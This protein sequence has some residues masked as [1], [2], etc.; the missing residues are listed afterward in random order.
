MLKRLV[1]LIMV[2]GLFGLLPTVAMGIEVRPVPPA[3]PGIYENPDGTWSQW[4]TKPGNPFGPGGE[5]LRIKNY[6]SAEHDI[7]D[8]L[9][10]GLDVQSGT[11]GQTAIDVPGTEAAEVKEVEK[12]MGRLR[13][14][15]KY[16]DPGE[17]AVGDEIIGEAESGGFLPSLG[18][19]AGAASGVVAVAATL[20][21]GIHIGDGIDELLGWPTLLGGGGGLRKEGGFAEIYEWKKKIELNST[22]ACSAIAPAVAA[23]TPPEEVCEAISEEAH[24][25]EEHPV[26]G[27]AFAHEEGIYGPS[28][29]GFLNPPCPTGFALCEREEEEEEH[30]TTFLYLTISQLRHEA[31]PA[32]GLKPGQQHG[33][34]E[35]ESKDVEKRSEQPIGSTPS[36]EGPAVV[37]PFITHE[38]E[39]SLLPGIGEAGEKAAP[40][41]TLATIPE[42][43]PQEKYSEYAPEVEAAGFTNIHEN[44][45]PESEIDGDT[46]PEGVISTAPS[47]GS[48]VT[49]DTEVNVDVNPDDAAT[50]PEGGSIGPPDLP[51]I[52]LPE[53]HLLCTT[54]P[55]G[56]PC[57]LV[58]QLEAFSG[59]ATAPVWKLGPFK[60]AGGTI[61][62]AEI[63]LAT[64]EPIMEVVRPFMVLFGTIGIVLLFYRI[65]TGH[66]IGHGENPSGEVPDP[67][68]GFEIPEPDEGAYL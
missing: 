21:V 55:F 27:G 47:P 65:F 60:W 4:V 57:W 29:S 33:I 9:A 34:D 37:L 59:T 44:V 24:R 2:A 58:K 36:R 26:G 12:M 35:H 42:I 3:E 64:L 31:F 54:M 52:K 49:P 22:E 8:R 66:S 6:T 11:S 25:Y 17:A 40:D 14:G 63:N 32:H 19:V 68:G 50:P 46:G 5:K 13:T 18:E 51:G 38:E 61:P 1:T 56:V 23:A 16:A 20:D 39:H 53:L 10:K 41:P 67:E 43:K 30:G 15:E 7:L 48:R 45:V 62:K 28:I